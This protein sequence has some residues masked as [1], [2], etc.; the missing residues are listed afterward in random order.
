MPKIMGKTVK[1]IN[2]GLATPGL[3][4]A[5][6]MRKGGQ[7]RKVSEVIAFGALRNLVQ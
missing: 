1:P 5:S 3:E 2:Q 7:R 6:R 4:T